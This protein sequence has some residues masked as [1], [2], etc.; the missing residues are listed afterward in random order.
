[1]KVTITVDDGDG[2]ETASGIDLSGT[3]QPAAAT[4]TREV[5]AGPAP[6]GPGGPTAAETS[7]PVT[8]PAAGAT[9]P[10]S[11]GPAPSDA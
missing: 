4:G 10:I 11:A 6:S 2:G 5:S 7:A 9:Q 8:G 3:T 1:M